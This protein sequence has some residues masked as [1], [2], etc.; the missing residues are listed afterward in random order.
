MI[1]HENEETMSNLSKESIRANLKAATEGY[2]L[3]SQSSTRK[4]TFLEIRKELWGRLLY[5]GM[6]CVA[7]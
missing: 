4:Q 5:R 2:P 3:Q 7:R 6:G 1:P